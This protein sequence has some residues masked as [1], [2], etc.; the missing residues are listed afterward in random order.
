ME[1]NCQDFKLFLDK[2]T[3]EGLNKPTHVQ[4]D[5]AASYRVTGFN[6]QT[7]FSLGQRKTPLINSNHDIK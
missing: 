5:C 2:L 4:M 1:Q 7:S 3:T 6:G